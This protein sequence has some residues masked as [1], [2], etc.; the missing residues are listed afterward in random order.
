MKRG[1]RLAVDPGSVRVGLAISDPDGILAT[2]LETV[3]RDRKLGSDLDQIAAIVADR[4]IVEV[5]V[6]RPTGL[7]GKSGPA[8][9]V[10]DLYAEQLRLR[11][12]SVPVVRQDERLSTVTATR[13]LR[14][15]GVRGK[16]QRS[17]IDQAA[18]VVILQQWLDSNTDRGG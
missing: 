7:S 4:E 13:H 9:E 10:A 3:S 2:P 17:V 12:A 11:L 18:A 1:R 15:S 8:A 5:V 16:K 6:G 14:D